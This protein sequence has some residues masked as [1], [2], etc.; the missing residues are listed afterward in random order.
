M[1]AFR[2]LLAILFLVLLGYTLMVGQQHGYNLLPVFFADI[3]QIGWP[4]QFNVDFSTFLVL[5]ALWVA[6]RNHFSAVA[7]V[8]AV[9][10]FFAGGLF[11]TAY[12]LIVSWQTKGDLAAMLLGSRRAA[13]QRAR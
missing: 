4:G 3:A 11:L 6:W 1:A 12:L 2:I 7:L 8:L 9:I 5:S 13:A 10:A